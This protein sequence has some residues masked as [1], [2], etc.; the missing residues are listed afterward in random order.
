MK[1]MNKIYSSLITL[2]SS[3]YLIIVDSLS[4]LGA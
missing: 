2:H 4:T 1:Y 3:L